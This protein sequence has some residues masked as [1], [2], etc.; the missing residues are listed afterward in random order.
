MNTF[1]IGI[2]LRLSVSA[3]SLRMFLLNDISTGREKLYIKALQVFTSFGASK[4]IDILYIETL[5][6]FSFQHMCQQNVYDSIK[7]YCR[8]IIGFANRLTLSNISSNTTFSLTLINRD[9]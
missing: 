3:N 7:F 5:F 6:R 1:A 4:K 2:V 8:C 9:V